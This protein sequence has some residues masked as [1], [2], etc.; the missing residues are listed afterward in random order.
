VLDPYHLRVI[1]VPTN[2]ALLLSSD[3]SDWGS[4]ADDGLLQ[5]LLT[6][7]GY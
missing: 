1:L 2:A 6:V 4:L 3:L 7:A 5:V